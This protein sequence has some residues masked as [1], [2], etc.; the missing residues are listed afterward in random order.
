MLAIGSAGCSGAG[1]RMSFGVYRI[2]IHSQRGDMIYIGSTAQSFE[3]RKSEHLSCLRLNK[4]SNKYLQRLWNKYKEISFEIAE[5]CLDR[6]IVSIR[7]Q[8]H[9]ENTNPGVL[10]NSGPAFPSPRFGVSISD[11]TRAKM[12]TAAKKRMENPKEKERMKSIRLSQVMTDET[13]QKLS[14]AGKKNYQSDD[15]R[16]FMSKINKGRVVS[17][18][19]REKLRQANAGQGKGEKQ[20]VEVVEKKRKSMLAYHQKRRDEKCKNQ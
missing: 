13:R 20:A 16:A 12:S 2:V 18:E 5:V 17:E 3:Q 9:I 4:H 8:W 15:G 19:T 14:D 11:E 1:D 10:V 6:N 7:E